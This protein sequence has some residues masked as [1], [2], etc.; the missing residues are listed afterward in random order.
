MHEKER[1]QITFNFNS[2][3]KVC[4]ERT[5]N[6]FSYLDSIVN[7]IGKVT[8]VFT[9]HSESIKMFHYINI[10]CF[11]EISTF[12]LLNVQTDS[13]VLKS[14]VPFVVTIVCTIRLAVTI[15]IMKKVYKKRLFR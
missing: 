5:E 6:I 7:G 2:L 1:M 3:Y 13:K 8:N 15:E 10:V 12:I 11:V 14:E 4:L 9:S